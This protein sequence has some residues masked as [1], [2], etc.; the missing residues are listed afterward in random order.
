LLKINTF[1]EKT[2]KVD[3]R[4]GAFWRFQP[5]RSS[6]Q[7]GSSCRKRRAAN[8]SECGGSNSTSPP[9]LEILLVITFTL[10]GK[11][12]AHFQRKKVA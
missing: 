2:L 5:I 10:H 6:T 11:K 8:G 4:R 7:R 3:D 9:D 1:T 12:P